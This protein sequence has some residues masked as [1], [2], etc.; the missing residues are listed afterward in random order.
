MKGGGRRGERRWRGSRRCRR[1][2]GGSGWG[3]VGL[4]EGMR[5]MTDSSIFTNKTK[6]KHD[7]SCG[8]EGVRFLDETETHVVLSGLGQPA[9]FPSYTTTSALSEEEEEEDRHACLVGLAAFVAAHPDVLSVQMRA[10]YG[11]ANAVASWI[12]QVRVFC[13]PFCPVVYSGWHPHPRE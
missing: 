10:R 6:Q 9:P 3:V 2:T 4:E 12:I 7:R 8:F 1:G 11:T 5:A 13:L